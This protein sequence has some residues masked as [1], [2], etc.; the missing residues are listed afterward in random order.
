MSLISLFTAGLA[1]LVPFTSAYT[2]PVGDAPEGNPI[3]TPGLN[4]VVPVG[5]A[6]PITWQPTT[7][8]T[9]TLVLLKGPSTNAVP[10]YPIVEAIPN[11]GSYLWTPSTDLAPGEVGYGIQ[12]IVDATGQ[13]QYSTQFGISNPGYTGSYGSSSTSASSEGSVAP[14]SGYAAPTGYLP[15]PQNS[16]IVHSTGYLPHNTTH[17]YP[18]GHIKTTYH[19]QTTHKVTHKPEA[20]FP[21]PSATKPISTPSSTGGAV[22]IATSFAG[23]VFAMGVAVLAL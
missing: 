13:Y 20:S 17:A 11:T 12:L 9:V 3:L 8:G 18:T 14:S 5:T 1:C 7:E 15:H 2:Q 10:Q 4:D 21:A 23:A 22:A 19:H 6:Y 16:T